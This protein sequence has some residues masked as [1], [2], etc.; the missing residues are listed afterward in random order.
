V[1][2]G[3][4]EHFPDCTIFDMPQRSDAW[5][6]MREGKLTGSQVGAW[7]AEAPKCRLTV[8]EI[9][10]SLT[11]W[12]I[13]FKKSA[14][15]DEILD[16]LPEL[17]KVETLTQTA[18][19]AQEKAICRMLGAMS[20]CDVPDEWE[21]DPDGPPPRSPGLWA[22][23]NGIRL[24][25]EAVALFERE[26]SEEVEQV[27]FCRHKSGIA[28]VS[29]DGL[30]KGKPIGFE[31]KAPLPSTH[32]EYFRA[33]VLP[34]SYRDQVHFSMA[35]TGA[36]AWWFQSYCPG[37]PPFRILVERDEYTEQMLAGISRFALAFGEARR[38]MEEAWN[39]M[40]GEDEGRRHKGS[41]FLDSGSF[42]LGR[43]VR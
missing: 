3:L 15:R 37:L 27:G 5:H 32:V 29:P 17:E 19:K 14:K 23:W 12:D 43:R 21:V 39:A 41:P 31:G 1:K 26:T 11:R 6:S 28:G 8:P 10:E 35:V 34:D 36:Q 18:E 9:Q 24:E 20:K 40:Q 38:E 33:G 13:P 16:L 7:I 22:I 2:G 4:A 30:V 42:R 25:P